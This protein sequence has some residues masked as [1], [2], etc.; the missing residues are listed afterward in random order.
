MP[1]KKRYVYKSV[2]TSSNISK[3]GK[4]GKRFFRNF[5]FIMLCVAI[6]VTIYIAYKK[7]LDIAYSS[8]KMTIKDIKIMGSK[9]VTKTEIRELLPFNIGD[10]LLRI[11]PSQAEKEIKKL[12]PELK[13][14]VIHRS[15]HKVQVKLY[16]RIPEAFIVIN[17]ELLGVDFDDMPFPLRGFMSAMKV[18][19]LFYNTDKERKQLLDFIKRFRD[20]CEDFLSNILEIKMSSTG[21]II[22]IIN[23]NTVVFWGDEMPEHLYCKFNKFKKI[24]VDAMSRYKNIE[25]IDMTLYSLGRAIVKPV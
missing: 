4:K 2:Y 16:E 6:M 20:V 18:P 5:L 12:K 10:N 19:K 1:K 14:V 23:S 24:Y 11:N 21:D 3:S 17:D 13:N 9:N 8:D 7:L 22:F 15:W 25:Y